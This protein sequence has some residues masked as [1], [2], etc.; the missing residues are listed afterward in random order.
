MNKYTQIGHQM[1][2]VLMKILEHRKKKVLNA[3]I[4]EEPYVML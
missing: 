2:I 1:H 3:Q 4:G